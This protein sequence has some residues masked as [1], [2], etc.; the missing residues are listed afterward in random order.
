MNKKPYRSPFDP[1]VIVIPGENDLLSQEISP[2]SRLPFLIQNLINAGGGE[3]LHVDG[4]P[5]REYLSMLSLY[6]V[7]V[8]IYNEVDPEDLDNDPYYFWLKDFDPFNMSDE[9]VAAL[10]KILENK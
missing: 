9:L 10:T 8:M 7:Y 2:E 4:K 3:A 5:T 1:D 6:A